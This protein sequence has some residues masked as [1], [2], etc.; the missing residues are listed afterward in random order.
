MVW[1]IGHV[2]KRDDDNLLKKAMMLEVNGQRKRERPKMTWRRP[3]KENVKKV[4]L[5]IKK[6]ADR[7]RWREDVRA[8]AEG[9]RCI[10]PLSVTRKKND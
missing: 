6:A 10:R 8:I 9:M 1:T 7:T 3:V 5:K 4:R 2:I